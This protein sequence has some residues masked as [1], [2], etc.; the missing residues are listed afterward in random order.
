LRIV[1]A[2][3]PNAQ[4]DNAAIWSQL[5]AAAAKPGVSA[6]SSDTVAASLKGGHAAEALKRAA[7]TFSGAA[8]YTTD[9]LPALSTPGRDRAPA[10]RRGA[11]V[12]I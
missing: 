10:R 12:R 7:K 8:G 9:L 3:G 4:L 5:N 2:P 6:L 1:W 11:V